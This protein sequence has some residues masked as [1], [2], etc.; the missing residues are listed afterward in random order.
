MIL[1][2]VQ[3]FSA[4]STKTLGLQSNRSPH[5]SFKMSALDERELAKI[6]GR[7]ADKMILLD[8]PG[9]GTPEMVNCCHGG[10]DNCDYSHVFDQMNAGRAKWVPSYTYRQLIDGREHSSPWS[11]VFENENEV[12]KKDFTSRLIN[13]PYQM[14]MGALSVPADEAPSQEAVD[15]FFNALTSGKELI[16]KEQLEEILPMKVKDKHGVVWGAFKKAFVS[17]E[18]TT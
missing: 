3:G 9:A 17:T 1:V 7:L 14:N 8:V 18:V 13:L 6:F 12:N 5:C 15:D 10:C 11:K 16:S 2:A 4:S